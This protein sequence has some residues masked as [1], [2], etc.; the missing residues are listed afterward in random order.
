MARERLFQIADVAAIE[1]AAVTA[2]EHG[3]GDYL[4]GQSLAL[5]AELVDQLPPILRLY[6]G[7]AAVLY[8]DY[9]HAD[10]IKIHI[11][12]GKVSLMRFDDFEHQ[13]LPKLMERVKIKLREQEI[14]FFNYGDEFESPYLYRKSRFINEESDHYP[15]QVAFEEQLTSLGLLDFSGYGPSFSEFDAKLAELRWSVDGFQLVRSN[16][17]PNIDEQCG[18]NFSYRD[19]IECGETQAA[20]EMENSPQ[21]AA[22]FNALCDL[23]VNLL[24]PVIDY[25]GMIE[26]TF[27]FCSPA[28]ARKIPGR[29]DPK[30]DQHAAHELNRRG[31][32]V[33]ERLGAAVDFLIED[34]DML[35]VAQWVAANTPFDR[36]YF[37]RKDK[38]IHLSVGPNHDRAI[39]RMV[40]SKSARL[41][42]RVTSLSDFL[43]TIE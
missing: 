36:L 8:G 16:T 7:C 31:R 34:E 9:R 24:D 33:C 28:L 23:A 30:R 35:E 10:L 4:P 42:P 20:M 41:I 15:E 21:Q 27:G 29:I 3:L 19:L 13:A 18:A 6:V 2:S 32:L 25:F 43:T 17:L 22:S 38:P 40:A 26:L 1:A 12:S 14:D 37:Y 5:Q 39:V 11:A